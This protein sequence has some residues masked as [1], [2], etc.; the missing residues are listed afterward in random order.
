M[1]MTPL[2]AVPPAPP[3]PDLRDPPPPPAALFGA[4]GALLLVALLEPPRFFTPDQYALPPVLPPDFLYDPLFFG[5]DEDARGARFAAF[6]FAAAAFAA[7]VCVKRL[8]N[9]STSGSRG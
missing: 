3:A 2:Q 5:P 9:S 4:A 1:A 7:I 6:S 8:L